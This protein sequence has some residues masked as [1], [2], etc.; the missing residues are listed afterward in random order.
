MPAWLISMATSFGRSARR[1]NVIGFSGSSAASVPQPLAVL[2]QF[3][4][5]ETLVGCGSAVVAMTESLS[6]TFQ[7]A[8]GLHKMRPV[9]HFSVDRQ[10]ASGG[11]GLERGD[12]G[13]RLTHFIGRRREGGIDDRNLRGMDCQLPGE[14][15]PARGRR[16]AAQTLLVVKVAEDAVDRLHARGDRARQA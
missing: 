15:L 13:L 16:F 10:H 8:P 9:H 11:L 5:S 7:Y 4:A 1:S 2:G 3:E 14:T 6:G 12:H